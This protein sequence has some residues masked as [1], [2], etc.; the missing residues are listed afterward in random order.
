MAAKAR[1]KI[2]GRKI[3]AGPGRTTVGRKRQ[4]AVKA[5]RAARS[6]SKPGKPRKK[7]IVGKSKQSAPSVARVVPRFGVG[8]RV[9]VS[10]LYPPG[11]IRTPYYIRG[12]TGLVERLCG[13]F[14]NPEE[15]AFGRADG[16]RQP[17]YRVRFAQRVVWPDYAGPAADTVDIEI[18]QHWLEAAEGRT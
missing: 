18:Y 6:R 4:V 8:D 2:K 7:R 11:H 5:S 17:L 9:K 14:G 3:K 12:K 13:V 1:G 15:L 16:P 10:A